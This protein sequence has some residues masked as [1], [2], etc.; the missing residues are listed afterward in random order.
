MARNKKKGTTKIVVVA[1]KAGKSK[2][3]RKSK[4]VTGKG[5]Y[6]LP[7]AYRNVG[8]DL[9]SAI[10]FPGFGRAMG[11]GLSMIR[12]HGD[13]MA[14]RSNSLMKGGIGTPVPKFENG[15]RRGVRIVEREFLGTVTS[16]TTFTNTSYPINPG[17]NSTFPWLS[18]LAQNF[19]EYKF[20]GLLFEYV[21][22]SAD[23][24]GS[25]QSIGAVVMSTDYD[26]SDLDFSSRQQMENADYA[27]S[28]RANES[29]LHPCEC[30][31][32]ER[33]TEV[34]YVRIGAVPSS[35]DVKMYDLGKFQ[36]AVDGFHDSTTVVG[37]LWVSYDITLFKKQINSTLNWALSYNTT[38]ASNSAPWGVLATRVSFGLCD[39][40]PNGLTLT[41][42]GLPLG[43]YGVQ[44]LYA[45]S[46]GSNY[47]GYPFTIA[48]TSNCSN[49]AMTSI[50][51]DPLGKFGGSQ[52]W[53]SFG[54]AMVAGSSVRWLIVTGPNPS[55]T[56]NAPTLNIPANCTTQIQVFRVSSSATAVPIVA[57]TI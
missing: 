47:T 24:N 29:L 6:T 54:T 23:W 19:E 13:Y 35:A 46:S 52:N 1:P 56:V 2:K 22:M 36:I 7:A 50:I 42:V 53:A 27:D 16:N 18:T 5:D 55:I 26:S 3:R 37:E 8:R 34:G 33:P 10:G 45:G 40:Q 4:G 14:I 44:T 31:P 32:V 49:V 25:N 38:L 48:S 17:L 43:S 30:S 21:S 12:G 11:A 57:D 51:S 39:I 15:G 41:F 28:T 9:G 20:N